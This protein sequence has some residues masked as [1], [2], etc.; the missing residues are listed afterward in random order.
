MTIIMIVDYSLEIVIAIIIYDRHNYIEWCLYYCLKQPHAIFLD[1][2]KQ[3]E[4][5]LTEKLLE[6][7]TSNVNYT[8]DWIL[9]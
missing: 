2:N 4:N 9:L 6:Y 1:V 8:L 5:T 7:Y 3:A